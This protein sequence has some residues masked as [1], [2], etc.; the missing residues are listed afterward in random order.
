MTEKLADQWRR[1]R[2]LKNRPSDARLDEIAREAEEFCDTL[3]WDT[4]R[5]PDGSRRLWHGQIEAMALELLELRR[6]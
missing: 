6:R 4:L 2:M 5:D 3:G 1:E